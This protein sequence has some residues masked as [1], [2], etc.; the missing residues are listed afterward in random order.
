[1]EPD[2]KTDPLLPMPLHPPISIPTQHTARSQNLHGF[3]M[4]IQTVKAKCRNLRQGASVPPVSGGITARG[5]ASFLPL[6]A[7]S[8][9]GDD[10][11][12]K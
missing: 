12:D 5:E 6:D 7:A 8:N 4:E 1:M 2:V 10:G 9:A 3:L 11:N